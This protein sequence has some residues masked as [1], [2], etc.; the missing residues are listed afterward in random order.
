VTDLPTAADS[1][2]PNTS[3]PLPEAAVGFIDAFAAWAKTLTLEDFKQIAPIL[4]TLKQ[5]HVKDPIHVPR[6][7]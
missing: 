4:Q 5:A 7:S 6:T 1:E 3:G 2:D